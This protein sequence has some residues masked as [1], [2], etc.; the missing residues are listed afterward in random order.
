MRALICAEEIGADRPT[1]ELVAEYL[2][3]PRWRG[4]SAYPP[5]S[6]RALVDCST[7]RDVLGWR[8]KRG[9]RALTTATDAK[10]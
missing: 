9:W 10:R 7:A 3:N 8:P 5:T 2:P 6:R 4:G 1:T